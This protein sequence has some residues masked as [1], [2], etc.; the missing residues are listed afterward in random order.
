ME[1]SA[2]TAIETAMHTSVRIK[3]LIFRSPTM[4][5]PRS[6][7]RLGKQKGLKTNRVLS[8]S[9]NDIRIFHELFPLQINQ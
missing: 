8:E 1:I 9:E 5:V 2:F 4:L 7:V 3:K 6:Q